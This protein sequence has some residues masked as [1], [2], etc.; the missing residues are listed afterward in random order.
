MDPKPTT[1]MILAPG[2]SSGASAWRLPAADDVPAVDDYIDPPEVTRYERIDGRRVVAMPAN[3]EH[4]DPHF[5]LDHVVAA[6]VADGYVGSSDLK[7]R[8]SKDTEFASDACVR[9]EGKDENGKRHL[10]ELV[11]EVVSERSKTDTDKRAR[12]FAKRG[13]RRQIAIFVKTGKVCEWSAIG[14]GWRPLD[15]R[16]TIKDPCLAHPL[17]VRALLDAG[18]AEVA[19]A[20]A[21][22]AKG[23][24]A[25]VAMKQKSRADGKEEGREEGRRTQA[26]QMVLRA[27]AKRFGPA[28]EDVRQRVA[29]ASADALDAWLDCV[30]DAESV[31]EALAGLGS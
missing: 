2:A 28:S 31:E 7:T 23:N 13:V 1:P 30:L 19:A 29:V 24:P 9:R 14:Q 16:R 26:S 3:P 8:V 18:R 5:L 12:E 20:L 27:F 25:I 22:E 21:M 17:E 4:A 15:P 10:E 11:F 6:H